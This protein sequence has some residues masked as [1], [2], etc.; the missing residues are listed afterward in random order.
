[1]SFARHELTF[2]L[3]NASAANDSR[4]SEIKIVWLL[5]LLAALHVF[6]FSAAFPFFGVVD[7][8]AHFDLAVRYSQG[9]IP[10][11]IA[12]PCAE[13]LPFLAMFDNREYLWSPES[14][15]G[16]R[17]APAIWKLPPNLA[18][19]VFQGRKKLY[20]AIMTNIEAANPPLYYAI[21][22][23]W[24][25][26]GKMFGLGGGQLLY[27]LRFLNVPLLLAL[28]LLGWIT[29]RTI[30]SDQIFIRLAVPALI[31][32]MPQA[33]F[34]A[35][36]NDV[37][38]PLTFGT[39]FLLLLKLWP[40]EIP[41]PRLAVA[42]GLALAA[43]FLSK[44]SNLPLLLVAGIFLAAKF[45]SGVR[46]GKTRAELQPFLLL[47]ACASLPMIAWLLWCKINFGDGTG[48][49][50][51]I[52]MLGWTHKPLAEWFHHPFFTPSGCWTFLSGNL[53]TFWQGEVLWHGQPLAIPAMNWFYSLFTL[54][55][56][57]T[58][59]VALC[60]RPVFF[61]PAQRAALWL[62]F[63]FL[64]AAL[65]FYALLSVQ[66]DFHD[67]FYPSREHPYFTSGR[68]MLGLLIPLLILLASGVNCLLARFRLHTKFLVLA[69]LL[70]FMLTVEIA[71][72]W[73]IFP[74]ECNWFHL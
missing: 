4:R 19:E 15:T 26:L 5:G 51:K 2:R 17:F 60:Q 66:F 34:S 71:T 72:D 32:F 31:A 8:Q 47:A 54:A 22:G 13:A 49:A 74:N 55:L 73:V 59:F 23:A 68:L 39:A 7:E 45:S 50:Q 14:Q 40:A 21:S 9:D 37:I 62:T 48:T 16:G 30:F 33:S 25:Q 61:Q 28:V 29:A 56:L 43:T 41:T 57:V 42:T 27:W 46:Q 38:S 6:I 58:V 44:I 35:V 12:P 53:A 70:L 10:R 65:G 69:A 64:A 3:V 36:N 67:C 20:Y 1:L 11:S 18:F 52:Q 24:W 63:S